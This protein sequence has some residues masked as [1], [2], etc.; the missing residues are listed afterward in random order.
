MIAVLFVDY[1]FV[2]TEMMS[3]VLS[4]DSL[5]IIKNFENNWF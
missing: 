2:I 5:H 4:L 3:N 1:F